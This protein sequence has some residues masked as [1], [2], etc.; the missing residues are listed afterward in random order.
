MSTERLFPIELPPNQWSEFSADGFEVPVT[1]VVYREDKPAVNGMPLGGIDTGCL[2]LETTGL[3]GY[4]TVFNSL[5]PR[6]G[7]VNQPL[8]GVKVDG[9][10][11]VLAA[12][13]MPGV[14][15]AQAVHYW[16]HYPVAD[17]EFE[18]DSPL[19]VGVRAWSPFIPGDTSASMAPGAVFEFHLR[20]P[21]ERQ[22]AGSLA[23]SF[24][25]I[26][27][28]EVHY[29][30]FER[31]QV[32]GEFSGGVA[33][34][35]D[36]RPA[37]GREVLESDNEVS[38]ALGVIGD[39]ACRQGPHLRWDASAWQALDRLAPPPPSEHTGNGMSVAVDFSLAPGGERVVRF[40]LAWYAPVW[41][42][43]GWRTAGGN[44]FRHM[45]AR[46][47]RNA[48]EVAVHL[49]RNHA[50]LLRRVL[51][52][53]SVVYGEAGLPGWLRDGLINILHLITET[54]VWAQAGDPV[55][56][57][58]RE[59]DGL[60]GLNESPR[61]CP[62]IE[63][64][65]CSFY[66]NLP[67]VYFFPELALST[68]RGQKAYQFEDGR[69]PWV[70]GGIT[71]G[72]GFYDVSAPAKGYQT[73]L[74][75]C[76]YVEM[77]NKLWRRSGDEAVLREFYDSCKR[78]T[79]FTMS[80]RPEYG[81]RQVISMPTGDAETEWFEAPEPG[82]RG[83]ATHIGGIR[84]THLRI[85]QRMAERMGDAEFAAQCRRW[86]EAGSRALEEHLWV[87]DYYLNFHEPE[88]D[89]R[90]DL[91]FGYQ[92]DGD[93]MAKFHGTEA[94]FPAERAKTVLETIRRCN[95]ALS[96][97]GA[98]NYA[99]PDGSPAEVG[100]YGT[101]AYFPPELVMLDMTYMYHGDQEFGLE[102]VRRCWENITCTQRLTWDQPNILRG[103]KDTGERVFGNDYYQNMMLWSL[104]AGVAG[105]DLA[106]PC[107]PGGLVDRMLAAGRNG[108]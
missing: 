63:C 39:L 9:K 103:D 64:L 41:W 8:M 86:F 76:C 81:D 10:S 65:P 53:Q 3:L 29:R 11:H 50:A 100:G 104:P 70:F 5:A 28:Y 1:G 36:R 40:V 106:G 32:R 102:L 105:Q 23:M 66:G 17:M 55:G 13:G 34:P 7:P 45:Y 24:P 80:L 91:V 69:P 21:S 14:P 73:S 68:L 48:E 67:V 99:L 88:T 79:V 83:M 98:V 31:R 95:V 58:C 43:S 2:D 47:F 72:S 89:S 33:Q 96:R 108:Q 6:R 54:G 38:Y 19:S 84:L 57:W 37:S 107:E 74:N 75:G 22:L 12:M 56:D 94:A 35:A 51:A 26:E 49:A 44:P 61:G 16:G 101:Y 20:N 46:R 15:P 93:W 92:L 71:T 60:F 59:E 77:V 78:A 62:Q 52:W 85:V 87:G 4:L 25:G 97:T 30:P 82:W 42:G 90:S 18:L 27:P